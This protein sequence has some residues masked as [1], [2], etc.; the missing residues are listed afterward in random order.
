MCRLLLLTNI[1]GCGGEP[2]A[3]D[4]EGRAADLLH[5]GRIERE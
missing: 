1:R 2:G 3:L 4:F 5:F